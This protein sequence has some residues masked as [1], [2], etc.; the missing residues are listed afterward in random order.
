MT[1]CIALCPYRAA[2]LCRRCDPVARCFDEEL[3]VRRFGRKI[4]DYGPFA[5]YEVTAAGRRYYSCVNG[6]GEFAP[7]CDDADAAQS[8]PPAGRRRAAKAGRAYFRPG[9]L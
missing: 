5:L 8:G 7:A 9:K 3:Y 4:K 2:E 6:R 1:E